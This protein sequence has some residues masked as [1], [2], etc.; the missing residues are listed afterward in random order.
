MIEL[1]E[2]TGETLSGQ[3]LVFDMAKIQVPRFRYAEEPPDSTPVVNH[4]STER[5]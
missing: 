3:R 1:R 4:A 2:V 5:V